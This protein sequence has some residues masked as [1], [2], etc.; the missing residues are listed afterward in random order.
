M[1]VLQRLERMGQ[2]HAVGAEYFIQTTHL[3]Q[4][5]QRRTRW[6]RPTRTSG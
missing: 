6:P 4:L 5:A 1:R 3:L 2:V